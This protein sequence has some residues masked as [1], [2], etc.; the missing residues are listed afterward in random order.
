MRTLLISASRYTNIHIIECMCTCTVYVYL[1]REG[2]TYMYIYSEREVERE[3]DDQ[4]AKEGAVK[5]PTKIEI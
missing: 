2:S 4:I 1:E 3:R 5:G